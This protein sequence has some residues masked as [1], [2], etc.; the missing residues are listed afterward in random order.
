[1]K[2][3]IAVILTSLLAASVFVGCDAGS[4]SSTSQ[5]SEAVSSS[6]NFK[7]ANVA[8]GYNEELGNFFDISVNDFI[9]LL[10]EHT[11][12]SSGEVSTQKIN[13][14]DNILH[15]INF[16]DTLMN[17]GDLDI[18]IVEDSL[19]QQI[20]YIVVLCEEP[21]TE[22]LNFGVFCYN[23]A[24]LFS[25]KESVLSE[26]M[27]IPIEGKYYHNQNMDDLSVVKDYPLIYSSGTMSEQLGFMISLEGSKVRETNNSESSGVSES[28]TASSE[29]V[30]QASNEHTLSTGNYVV[31]EDIP[32]GKYDISLVSGSGHCSIDSSKSIREFFGTD[33]SYRIQEYKNCTL[34]D[35][36]TI[37]ISGN[38]TLKFTAK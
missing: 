2:K 12:L 6:T 7:T 34:K 36:D 23:V 10:Q 21:V 9:S 25:T 18:R 26:V 5:E 8:I 14:G 1:M 27:N 28:S 35:K 31:G 19:S 22:N 4:S 24:F 15:I 38:L 32:A 29:T 30:S 3:F 11:I 17:S 37:D 33:G 16:K 20:K 13:V